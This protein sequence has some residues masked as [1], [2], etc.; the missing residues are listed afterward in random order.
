M[1]ISSG[2]GV[3]WGIS[4]LSTFGPLLFLSMLFSISILIFQGYALKESADFLEK[5]FRWDSDAWSI[6]N[7]TDQPQKY[8]RTVTTF[9]NPPRVNLLINEGG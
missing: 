7:P 6:A 1:S 4:T 5:F 8:Q 9:L 2:G 3:T